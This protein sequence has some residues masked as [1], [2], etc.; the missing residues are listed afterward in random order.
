MQVGTPYPFPEAAVAKFAEDLDRIIVFEEL[1]HVIEDELLKL[2]GKLH[3]GFEVQASSRV[4][5]P[6][7]A[8][9]RSMRSVRRSRNS[10]V[11]IFLLPLSARSNSATRYPSAPQS[12]VQDALIAVRSMP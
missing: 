7:V 4:P 5:L 12:C 11:S 10:S 9:T 2:C 3:A 6:R 1:D 8:K